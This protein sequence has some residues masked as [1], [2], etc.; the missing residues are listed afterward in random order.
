MRAFELSEEIEIIVLNICISIVTSSSTI[1]QWQGD[2]KD[3]LMWLEIKTDL[4]WW[5]WVVG[6]E[7]ENRNKLGACQLMIQSP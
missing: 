1:V 3:D 2:R 6:V 7:G 4:M 5:W